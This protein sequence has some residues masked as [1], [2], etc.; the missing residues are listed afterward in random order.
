MEQVYTFDFV[1]DTQSIFRKLI[2]VMAKP[3]VI[4]N[5][6]R[7]AQG[8]PRKDK[9]L[10]AL[11]C[12]LLDNEVSFYV[13]K[14]ENFARAL[15]DET[16]SRR[17]KLEEADF[18]FLTGS[19]NYESIRNMFFKV[20][21]GTLENPQ[22]SAVFLIYCPVLSGEENVCLTGPGIQGSKELKTTEYIKTIL[23]IRQETAIEYPCGIDLIFADSRGNLMAVPRLV[24]A[25][26]K[27]EC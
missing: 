17:G 1:F 25:V 2:D 19:L 4:Q 7:E 11:G 14:D 27:K 15:L 24:K 21:A 23:A 20:K 16:L 3:S 8:F 12:T 13:E 18:V 22:D 6:S 26:Q 5:I 10:L 9:E